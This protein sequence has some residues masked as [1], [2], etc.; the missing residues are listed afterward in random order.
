MVA[1]VSPTSA[2][3]PAPEAVETKPE[4]EKQG[5]EELPPVEVE[6]TQ[7]LIND[8]QSRL[9]DLLSKQSLADDAF[10]QQHFNAQMYIS[11]SILIRHTSMQS[12]GASPTTLLEAAKAA[13]Q[14]SEKV[15]LD[16]DGWMV[17]PLLKPRRNTLILHDLPEDTTEEE[18]VELFASSPESEAFCSLKPDVNNTAFATF[19]NDES[20]QN[21]ALW[22]R[23]QKHKGAVIKCAIKSEHFVRSFY[24]ASPSPMM[25]AASP[26]MMPGQ[27]MMW[28]PQWMQV[29]QWQ[30]QTDADAVG[31]DMSQMWSD[32]RGWQQFTGLQGTGHQGNAESG[33]DG[34]FVRRDSK[35]DLKGKGKGKGKGK[36]KGGGGSFSMPDTDMMQMESLP[37]VDKG[38]ASMPRMS[39]ENFP[40]LAGSPPSEPEAGAAAAA[41]GASAEDDLEIGYK[42]N[43]RQYSRQQII[44][45]CNSMEDIAKPESYQRL[46]SENAVAL[47]R[48]T[49]C[50]DWAPLPTPQI[51]F[52]SFNSEPASRNSESGRERADSGASGYGGRKASWEPRG[53]RSQ[54]VDRYEDS[55]WAGGDTKWWE[56]TAPRS[57]SRR[58]SSSR[59]YRKGW[60]DYSE[61][62][63][64]QQ[65]VEKGSAEQDTDW[66]DQQA[67]RK[68][69]WAEKVRGGGNE[70]TQYQPR[71][72]AKTAKTEEDDGAAAATSTLPAASDCEPAPSTSAPAGAAK[73]VEVPGD[74]GSEPKASD[75]DAQEARKTGETA[76]S[77][78]PTW[79]DKVRQ[80]TNQR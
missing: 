6:F 56:P 33:A 74:G 12:L 44:E 79:A 9:E 73:A 10:I 13:A 58:R 21:A 27:V 16:K 80:G 71:W 3:E 40:P 43:F 70:G 25:Q 51:P 4:E 23:G 28:N 29:Q 63:Y 8:V 61:K 35:G 46:E 7:T 54:S 1:S 11:L 15:T 50:K 17:R 26:Y 75:N 57:K 77:S 41:T 20:A 47:F 59:S 67:S 45:V 72:V 76:A 32:G 69:S 30:G 53:S 39:N 60:D 78:A 64:G 68:P 62:G 66:K 49:A 36:R 31:Y 38:S 5:D 2:E 42:H 34:H 14:Q 24:P 19:K 48:E 22:L 65:W 52:A 55:E 37:R 18:L